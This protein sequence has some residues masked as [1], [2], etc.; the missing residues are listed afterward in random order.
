MAE[1]YKVDEG[2]DRGFFKG[3][4]CAFG[5]F[6]GVHRGHRF[7][8]DCA[9]RTAGENGERSVVLTFDID[10][11]EK[12]H[13]KRLKKLMTNEERLARLAASGVDA[14][15]VLPFTDE[16]AASSPEAFLLRTFDGEP[17]AHLHVGSDFRFGAKA[18][19]TVRELGAWGDDVGME[20]CVHDLKGADGIPITA[21]RIRLLLAEG[22]VEE[23]N[24]LL[25][26]PYYMCGTVQP[27]RGEGA[28]LGFRTANFVVPDQLRPLGDGVYAAWVD[29]AGV[30][31]KA[32][33]N[34]GVAA[35]F[36]DRSTATCEVHLLD[37]DDDLYGKTVKVE[38]LHWLRPMRRF[39]NLDEL[40]STV[41]GNIEWVRENL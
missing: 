1:I 25:G 7:L 6:D 9:R 15:A 36:S 23:A 35:T 33:V 34:V 37:F 5:V 16:F 13:P 14:V 29:V 26:H 19:G 31:Y 4:S 39:D 38:L 12:F 20:V 8:I 41:K 3:S 18:C 11:D 21:T 27:G 32:A 40:I 28:D 24:R 2:F 22:K 30:R 10:P 17:P